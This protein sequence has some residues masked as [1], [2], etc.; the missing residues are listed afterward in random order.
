MRMKSIFVMAGVVLALTGCGKTHPPQSGSRTATY[1]ADALQQPDVEMRRKAAEKLGPLVLIDKA[2]L[3]ALAGALKDQDAEVRAAA[4]RSLG[5]Y[6]GARGQEFLPALREMEQQDSDPN[7]REAAAKAV[8]RL[9][10][11]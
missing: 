2:A 8:K 11:S 7:V 9:S 4:V 1:W 6:T 5:V 3:P 10:K